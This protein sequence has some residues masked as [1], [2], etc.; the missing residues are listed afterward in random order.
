MS[1]GAEAPSAMK[2]TGLPLPIKEER[3]KYIHVC[4]VHYP[5]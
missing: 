1:D 3:N 5:L 2:F 4:R